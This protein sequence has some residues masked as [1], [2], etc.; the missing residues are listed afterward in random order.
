MADEEDEYDA[1]I[2]GD[3]QPLRGERAVEWI[4]NLAQGGMLALEPTGVGL[5]AVNA[6][7][8]IV[9]LGFA[10]DKKAQIKR[11]ERRIQAMSVALTELDI[12]LE[13]FA[14]RVAE[15]DARTELLSRVLEAAASTVTLE[16]K[17]EALGKVLARGLHDHTK[18]DEAISLVKILV[19]E[20][21]SAHLRALAAV[22]YRFMAGKGQTQTW[23]TAWDIKEITGQSI[24][25]TSVMNTLVANG[26]CVL[27]TMPEAKDGLVALEYNPRWRITLFGFLVLKLLGYELPLRTDENGTDDDEPGLLDEYDD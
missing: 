4:S 18:I 5:V 6:L 14:E 24:R 27:W 2:A 17:V 20:M 8:K 11:Q 21:E 26:A 22:N 7:E 9:K 15:S 13:D 25:N 1:Y 3:D 10:L 16:A 19:G 12:S 23:S